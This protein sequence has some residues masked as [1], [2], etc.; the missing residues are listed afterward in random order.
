[1]VFMEDG[2]GAYRATTSHAEYAAQGVKRM[3]HHASSPDLNPIEHIWKLLKDRVYV[4]KPC[5]QAELRQYITEEWDI[6]TVEDIQ[7]FTSS[8][9]RRC[10]AVIVAEGGPTKY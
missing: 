7:R 2:A 8:M 1:M 9:H 4:R 10:R 3:Y 5:T 6:I